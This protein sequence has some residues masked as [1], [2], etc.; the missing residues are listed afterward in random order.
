[1]LGFELFDLCLILTDDRLT[2]ADVEIDQRD[3]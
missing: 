1:M 2:L 3:L